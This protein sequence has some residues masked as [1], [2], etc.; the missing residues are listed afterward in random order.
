MV[1]LTCLAAAGFMLAC[2]SEADGT[3]DSSALQM[4]IA[5]IMN[6]EAK[7]GFSGYA[8]V[9]KDDEIVFHEAFGAADRKTDT[10]MTKETVISAGS[11]SKQVTAAAVVL[12]EARGELSL[13]DPLS[14]YYE[15]IPDDKKD[16]TIRQI[17]SHSAGFG[18]ALQNDFIPI[19]EETWLELVLSSPLRFLPGSGYAYSNDGFSLAAIIVQRVSGK[20]FRSFIRETFFDPLD[21]KHSGWFDDGVFDTDESLT[22]ATGY[23]NGKDDGAPNEWPRPS[24][25]LL[26]NGGII[27]TASDMLKWHRA[28]H[29]DLLPNGARE[30]L[31]Q[32]VVEVRDGRPPHDGELPVSHY[33][34]GW[35]IGTTTCGDIRIG[36][37]GA[38][39]THNVDYRY[40][41][42]RDTLVY[43]ASNKIDEHYGER[44]IMYAPR[45]ANA[46][47]EVL[48]ENCR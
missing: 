3:S 15:N 18:W 1:T 4:K 31:F 21:M 14:K 11:L 12:L 16:I 41:P 43:V 48:M 44:E 39:V 17:L 35:R 47:A 36:H 8:L 25:P 46:I 7:N 2:T 6:D 26:G 5:E 28:V 32:P 33:A 9:L 34:L 23:F 45:A 22:I 29:G 24:W 38:G 10:R 37:G 42:E 13:D 20:P 30:K 40:Y 19:S 27:W